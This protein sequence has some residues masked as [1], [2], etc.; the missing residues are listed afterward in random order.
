MKKINLMFFLVISNLAFLQKLP[1]LNVKP[2]KEKGKAKIYYWLKSATN[3]TSGL[4]NNF[5]I[6]N[7]GFSY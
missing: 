7:I 1:E 5:S 2:I 3:A 6:T 4:N